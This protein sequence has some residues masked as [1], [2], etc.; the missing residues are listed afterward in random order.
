MAGIVVMLV[1][2]S[3]PSSSAVASRYYWLAAGDQEILYCVLCYWYGLL[4]EGHRF[5]FDWSEIVFIGRRRNLPLFPQERMS[6]LG[7]F[8]WGRVCHVS[9][10]EVLCGSL[11]KVVFRDR[12]PKK[13]SWVLGI[14]WRCSWCCGYI[15]HVLLHSRAHAWIRA[16]FS[17]FGIGL[18]WY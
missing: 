9:A 1:N 15:T 4:F 12:V 10:F 7:W 16:S 17:Y 18:I 3:R 2:S 11:E 14:C 5:G 6:I 8:Y 13:M